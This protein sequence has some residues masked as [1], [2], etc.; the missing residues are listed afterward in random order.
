M[1]ANAT[2]KGEV[3]YRAGDG[4]LIRIPEGPI[5]VN[6]AFDSVVLSWGDAGNTQTTAIPIAEYERYVREGAIAPYANP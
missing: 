4:P 2:V 5:E 3:E 6:F 1:A